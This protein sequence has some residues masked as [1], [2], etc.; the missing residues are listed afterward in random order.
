[1]KKKEYTTKQF[2]KEY[3]N[4]CKKTGFRIAVTPV[5]RMSQDTGDWRLVLQMNVEK[6]PEE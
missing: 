1:M 5:W 6:L 3:Q 2:A 4:L